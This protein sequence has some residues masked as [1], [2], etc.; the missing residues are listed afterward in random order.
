ML[1]HFTQVD[2]IK[3]VPRKSFPISIESPVMEGSAKRPRSQ[4]VFSA[5]MAWRQL[6]RKL[7]EII[8]HLTPI[9]EKLLKPGA[10]VIEEDSPTNSS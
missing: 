10:N 3:L 9:L 2:L 4:N 1:Q 5:Q 8:L 6:L 7:L